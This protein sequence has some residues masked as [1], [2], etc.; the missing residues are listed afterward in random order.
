MH[1]DQTLSF[2]EN[3]N[4]P[5]RSPHLP[6]K[7]TGAHQ[8]PEGE[9]QPIGDWFTEP[10]TADEPRLV[11]PYTLTAGRIDSGV[12]LALEAPVEA[13]EV[14][15]FTVPTPSIRRRW[16]RIEAL[17]ASYEG[18]GPGSFGGR[19]V[20]SRSGGDRCRN[21]IGRLSRARPR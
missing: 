4:M 1:A 5:H 20:R 7:R 10:E 12:E 8:Q 2:L 16:W 6:E 19:R 21:G 17:R 9:D 13:L 15:A 18:I 11:R 14:G 3:H